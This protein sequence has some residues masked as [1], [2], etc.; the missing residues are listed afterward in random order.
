[1]ILKEEY[2]IDYQKSF[3]SFIQLDRVVISLSRVLI[4]PLLN[5]ILSLNLLHLKIVCSSKF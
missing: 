1:M 4:K 5:N 2:I 3:E